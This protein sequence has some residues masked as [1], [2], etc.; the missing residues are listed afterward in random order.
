MCLFHAR[1]DTLELVVQPERGKTEKS[2][3]MLGPQSS[4][5]VHVD[6]EEFTQGTEVANFPVILVH[7]DHTIEAG[8]AKLRPGGDQLE[9]A[10]GLCLRTEKDRRTPQG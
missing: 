9:G 8:A 4:L 10:V 1:T 2:D 5:F 7:L 6:V 3:Q